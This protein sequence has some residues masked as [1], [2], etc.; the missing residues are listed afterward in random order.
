MTICNTPSVFLYMM[1]YY[2]ARNLRRTSVSRFGTRIG[3]ETLC[4]LTE[5]RFRNASKIFSLK[6]RWKLTIPFWNHASILI[7]KNTMSYI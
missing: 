2:V 4:K 5:S 7:K 1:S 3:I 6:T